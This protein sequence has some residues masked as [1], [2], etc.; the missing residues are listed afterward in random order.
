MGPTYQVDV[1]TH[2]SLSN[3]EF[4]A[5]AVHQYNENRT[6]ILTNTG[7]DVAGMIAVPD[8]YLTSLELLSSQPQLRSPSCLL[9][10][11]VPPRNADK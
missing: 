5:Q 6:G 4:L 9:E 10:S 1:I 3:P 11:L 2:N 8:E 7:G